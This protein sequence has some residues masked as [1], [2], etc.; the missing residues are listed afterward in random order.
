MESSFHSRT[1]ATQLTRRHLVLV[2]LDCR[3]KRLLNSSVSVK[4]KVK[5]KVTL[6]V[7]VYRQSIRLGVSP[8]QIHD[9]RLF[10]N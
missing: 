3:L 7:A 9:Q 2:I 8:L 4:V 5:D 1:L 6:Q 10:F